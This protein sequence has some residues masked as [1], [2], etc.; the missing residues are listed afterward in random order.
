VAALLPKLTHY[1]QVK[2]LDCSVGLG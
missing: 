2:R 1:R